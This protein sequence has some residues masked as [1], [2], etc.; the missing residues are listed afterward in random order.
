MMSK[1]KRYGQ[2]ADVLVKHGLG[3]FVQQLFPGVHRFRRCKTCPIESVSTVS[4]WIRLA[5]EE[6]GPTFIK[7]GQ[8]MST[9]REMLP[10][11]LIEELTKLQDRANPLPFDQI[12]SVIEKECPSHQDYFREIEVAPIASASLA[13]V[14]RGWLKDGTPV[15]L[16]VQ[17]PGIEDIIETD[18]LILASL[19]VRM[20]QVYPDIRAY[21]PTGMV[22]DFSH[23]IRKELDFALDGKNADILR[24]NMRDLEGVKIPRIYW[25]YSGPHLLV[26]E[27]IE[28]VRV[29]DV[30]AIREQGIDPRIVASRGFNAY[31]KQ[32]FEDGFFHGDPHPGNLLVTNDGT[33]VFLDFGIVGI[34]R[35]ERR[36]MFI[37][38]LRSIVDQDPLLMIKALEGL[39]VTIREQDRD[40]LRDDIYTALIQSQ[41]EQIGEIRFQEM[42]FNFSETLRRYR[43]KV[44]MNLMLMLKV[45]V[46]ALDEGVKL[47]PEFDFSK[48]A[49]PF[50]EEISTP[51]SILEQFKYLGGHTL[52]EAMDGFFELPRNVNKTLQQLSTGVFKIDILESD[53]KKFS[54]AL[55]RTSDRIL[56]G[57]VIAAI[58]VGSSLI[59]LSSSVSLPP[60][61]IYLA[62]V[63]YI[64]A[65]L[66]GFFA[67]YE[68]LF[69]GGG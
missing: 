60:F 67:V 47:D 23:Q 29:D 45:L 14:H 9:R 46:M 51:G 59:L 34:I 16:K 22:D 36:F 19:A 26:M 4:E 50:V 10:S 58:V 49:R 1:F 54:I 27:Y 8:I 5:I 31:L 55:D 64:V 32:I 21:N 17:R 13:Q 61:V 6:L 38:L 66:I 12:K 57:L 63:G 37:R 40:R 20:E 7:F 3:V 11:Q 68:V 39:G 28:G 24:K 48:E 42:A 15:A 2:I 33:L 65:I 69:K 30:T 53:I 43:L 25:E 52:V 18:L 56:V 44:P 35:P 62:A 41:G